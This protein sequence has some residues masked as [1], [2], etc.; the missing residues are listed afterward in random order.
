[1]LP[2]RLIQNRHILTKL[3]ITIWASKYADV[4]TLPS[5]HQPLPQKL[6]ISTALAQQIPTQQNP[7]AQT[8][9]ASTP[10]THRPKQVIDT[11]PK[12]Q[13][14]K[15]SHLTLP[16]HHEVLDINQSSFA[17]KSIEYHL[18]VMIY[19]NWIM[20]ADVDAL[21]AAGHEL[22]LS[23]HRSLTRQAKQQQLTLVS[24]QFD[25]PLFEDD[26]TGDSVFLANISLRGFIFG[27]MRESGQIK[28]LAP[29]TALPDYL[30]LQSIQN[31]TL[32]SDYHIDQM[33]LDGTTKKAFWQALHR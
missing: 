6:E 5:A 7:N 26:L 22:W 16:P 1:M 17:A 23:L 18:K 33:L 24:R 8:Q 11:P 3:G 25:Y 32:I 12:T 31:L 19:R 13:Q 9:L 27:C 10:V 28:Y 29:L 4:T 2:T 14:T 15:T 30:N 20:M 21:D